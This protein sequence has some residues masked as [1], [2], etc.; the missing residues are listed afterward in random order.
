[1]RRAHA[2]LLLMAPWMRAVNQFVIDS[3]LTRIPTLRELA[4]FGMKAPG[5][6]SSPMKS[7]ASSSW[8]RWWARAPPTRAR[9]SRKSPC[10]RARRANSR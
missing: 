8:R 6:T 4:A 3:S 9:A 10:W 2:D 1:M 5:A 7:R